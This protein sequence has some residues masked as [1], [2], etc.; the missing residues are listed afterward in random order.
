MEIL[1]LSKQTSIDLT[2]PAERLRFLSAVLLDVSEGAIRLLNLE[3]GEDDEPIKCTLRS[4]GLNDA[5]KFEALP[6]NF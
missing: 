5:P 2:K 4:A 3:P 6:Y 1:D